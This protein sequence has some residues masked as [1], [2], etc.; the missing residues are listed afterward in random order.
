MI[1][2]INGITNTPTQNKNTNKSQVNF[3]TM[4]VQKLGEDINF[5][6]P[7]SEMS[8]MKLLLTEVKELGVIFVKENNDDGNLIFISGDGARTYTL[9]QKG[10]PSIT[11]TPVQN[12]P[13]YKETIAITEDYHDGLEGYE[14]KVFEDTRISYRD[15]PRKGLERRFADTLSRAFG[16]LFEEIQ[17]PYI[18]GIFKKGWSDGL[19]ENPKNVEETIINE[20]PIVV[21][22]L[23]NGTMANLCLEGTPKHPFPHIDIN[24]KIRKLD[25]NNAEDAAMIKKIIPN[26]SETVDSSI[27]IADPQKVQKTTI[28][29]A[30]VPSYTRK[31]GDKEATLN[32]R[33]TVKR[34]FPHID[35]DGKIMKLDLK[36]PEH[37]ALIKKFT[38]PTPVAKA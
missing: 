24:G 7:V 33:G 25:L 27:V 6:N 15:K 10:K 11:V 18:S 4:S 16:V 14:Q 19:F 3:G 2:K 31:F 17:F 9:N 32:I 37:I 20:F 1:N 34:P 30:S 36:N 21:Y 23:R 5:I 29:K 35:M 22:K 38:Q 8:K 13:K 26:K 12:N 28:N